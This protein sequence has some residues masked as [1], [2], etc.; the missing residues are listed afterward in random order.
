[1][2][3]QRTIAQVI[4]VATLVFMI[5][6]PHRSTVRQCPGPL[7]DIPYTLRGIGI[8]EKTKWALFSLKN[9]R[10]EEELVEPGEVLE[11]CFTVIDIT[12][13]SAT[14]RS[15]QNEEL[16]TF[17]LSGHSMKGREPT[18][19][20]DSNGFMRAMTGFK[21]TA[22]SAE[23]EKITYPEHSN[24]NTL[25]QAIYL[26]KTGDAFYRDLRAL[27]LGDDA[28]AE[29]DTSP[30]QGVQI[31]SNSEG[32]LLGSIGLRKGDHIVAINGN[33]VTTPQE[34]AAY[35]K[36]AGDRPIQISYSDTSSE[37]ILSTAAMIKRG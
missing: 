30:Q 11:G 24:N 5:A 26:N 1:M 12:N 3:S 32:S 13:N 28:I 18:R 17:Y 19:H 8:E 23:V 22:V 7:A 20:G 34:V 16:R 35:I 6:I 25:P 36:A 2:P 14:L 33:F 29:S 21:S 37:G 10:Q 31:G 4:A 15:K 27:G 9:S